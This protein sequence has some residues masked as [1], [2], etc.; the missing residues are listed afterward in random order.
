MTNLEKH[1]IH[2]RQ[3]NS[4]HLPQ[5]N[6]AIHQRGVHFS[7]LKSLITILQILKICQTVQRKL[8]EP[9]NIFLTTCLFYTLEEHFSR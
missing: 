3:S 9:Y 2:P 6:L 7:V 1:I 8:K 4:L 5:T